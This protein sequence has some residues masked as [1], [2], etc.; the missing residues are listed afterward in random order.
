M[1]LNIAICDDEPIHRRLLIDYLEKVYYDELY[2]VLEFSSGEELIENYPEKLDILLLDIQMR[3]LNG[4]E[5][6]KKI[7]IFDTN[8]NIIFTTA[9]L[10]FL[11]QGYEVRAFRYLLKPIRYNE[12]SRH[13]IECK[14][15]IINDLKKNITIKDIIKG[16]ITIIPINSILYI[17]T[18]SRA[19]LIHTDKETY[20]TRESIKEFENQLKEHLFYRCHRS[21]LIN[22]NKVSSINKNSVFIKSDEILVSRYKIRDLKLII[23]KMLGS[24]L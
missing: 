6:A 8:V 14:K 21:Y 20:R 1:V 4:I 19:T 5:T 24:L 7:R 23:T 9:V 3:Y 15:D 18:E 12:F 10:D 11:Q 22:L 2:K 17:E 16:N 13:L